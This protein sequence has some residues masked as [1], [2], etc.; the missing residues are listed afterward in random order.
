MAAYEIVHKPFGTSKEHEKTVTID[1]DSEEDAEAEFEKLFK[2]H[3]IVSCTK[4]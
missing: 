1:G 3:K 4:K 2:F